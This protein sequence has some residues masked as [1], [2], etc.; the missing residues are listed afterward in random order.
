M[1]SVDGDPVALLLRAILAL[2]R[3]ARAERPPGALSLSALGIL[4]SLNR[5]GPMVATKLA[6]EERLQPQSLTRLLGDLER[7]QLIAR[8]RSESDR[9]AITIAITARGRAVLLEDLAARRAWLARA[10]NAAL[11]SGEREVLLAASTIMIRLAA[12]Q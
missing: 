7:G 2:G 12:N 11:T 4:G 3:R 6:A 1:A 5:L 8:K 9:R 10:M